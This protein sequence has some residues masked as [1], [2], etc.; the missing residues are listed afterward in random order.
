[1]LTIEVV[2]P[3]T[4]FIFDDFLLRTLVPA[5]PAATPAPAKAAPPAKEFE[6]MTPTPAAT[7][8]T[9]GTGGILS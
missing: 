3:G 4:F 5:N 8:V 9:V 6:D 2:V 1:M 7:G